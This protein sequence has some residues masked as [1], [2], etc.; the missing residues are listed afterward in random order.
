[1]AKKTKGSSKTA[2][3]EAIKKRSS[4]LRSSLSAWTESEARKYEKVYLIDPDSEQGKSAREGAKHL[5]DG[6]GHAVIDAIV[7]TWNNQ[8]PA[9]SVPTPDVKAPGLSDADV[10]KRTK[11]REAGDKAERFLK[12]LFYR[13]NEVSQKDVVALVLKAFSLWAECTIDVVNMLALQ[14]DPESPFILRV[15]KPTLCYP[16][17]SELGGLVQHVFQVQTTLADIK[18]TY[19]DKATAFLTGQDEDLLTLVDSIDRQYHVVWVEEQAIQ[20]II[21]VAHNLKFIPRAS[22]IAGANDFFEK[23]E[24]KRQPFLYSYLKS[25]VFAARNLQ[26]TLMNT[27]LV[28]YINSP[29]LVHTMDGNP[30]PIDFDKPYSQVPLKQGEDAAMLL[31][32]TI[33]AE[34]MRFNNELTMMA[35]EYTMPKTAMG[36]GD[37]SGN[38][39]AAAIAALTANALISTRDVKSATERLL[40]KALTIVLQWIVARN[41]E[42]SVWSRGGSM[43]TLGPNDLVVDGTEY[44]RVEVT[45]S[46]DKQQL[47]QMV[48]GLAAT[49]WNAR[50]AGFDTIGEILEGGGVIPSAAKWKQDVYERAF[51]EANLP[52]EAAQAVQQANTLTGMVSAVPA[53]P[54]ANGQAGAPPGAMPGTPPNDQQLLGAM[55]AGGIPPQG[56][57][58]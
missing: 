17:Y 11:A 13:S 12:A 3:F 56:G 44:S 34:Q 36:A 20:P 32:N 57:Q 23:E 50:L 43:E 54:S 19:G 21:N 53:A 39:P 29:I 15:P 28:K 58:Q 55:Q 16:L 6:H 8:A 18:E 5:Y 9:I 45:L 26:L 51:I 27:N 2:D 4:S 49:L 47:R 38:A 40:S 48:T 52:K 10:K 33:P 35:E 41:E 30:L 14:D 46:E 1:L 24:W 7:R 31:K 25:G 37:M 42:V 22:M